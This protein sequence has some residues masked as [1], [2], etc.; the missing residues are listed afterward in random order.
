MVYSGRHP[1]SEEGPGNLETHITA[2]PR[3]KGW[4]CRLARSEMADGCELTSNIDHIPG[5]VLSSVHAPRGSLGWPTE[6][7]TTIVPTLQVR[8]LK[9]KRFQ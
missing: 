8:K 4:P 9:S 5:V 6:L 1:L 7:S 2:F 3:V